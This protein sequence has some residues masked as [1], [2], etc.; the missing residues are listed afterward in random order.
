MR[1]VWFVPSVG[2]MCSWLDKTG[3]KDVKVLLQYEVGIDEQRRTAHSPDESLEDFLDPNDPNL[4]V[5]GYKVP[6]RA[7]VSAKA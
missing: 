5:E 2:A 4:T 1:N 7:L 6:K 3:F